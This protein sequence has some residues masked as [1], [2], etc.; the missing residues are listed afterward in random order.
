MIE[1][2][3]EGNCLVS[4]HTP[5]YLPLD[6]REGNTGCATTQR[7]AEVCVGVKARAVRRAKNKRSLDGS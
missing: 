2:I 6:L 1:F 4:L 3:P 5:N 7:C